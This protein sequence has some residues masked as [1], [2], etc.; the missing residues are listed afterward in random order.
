MFRF[1]TTAL[2]VLLLTAGSYPTSQPLLA[3]PNR[4]IAA[5]TLTVNTSEDVNNS[6]STTCTSATDGKC[7]LRRAILA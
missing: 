7:T 3:A 2:L 6:L 5:V 1:I 4:A